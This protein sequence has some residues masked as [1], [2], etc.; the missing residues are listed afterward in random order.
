LDFVFT[1]PFFRNNKFT[2]SSGIPA[3]S[4]ARFTR[5]LL[6][7]GLLVTIEEPSGRRPALFM[8]EPLIEIVRV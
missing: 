7:E 6:D 3:S 4:A 5:L 1:N 8:F 2:N